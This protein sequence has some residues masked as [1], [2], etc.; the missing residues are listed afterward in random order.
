MA[1]WECEHSADS[2]A[3]P[4]SVWERYSDV[5]MW[6]EW[7][8]GVEES[9]LDGEFEAG[10]KGTLKAP[11]LP[12]SRFE[13]AEVEPERR[14]VSTSRLPGG[15]IRLEH[16][17]EP[18]DAGTR[19]THRATIDGPLSPVWTRVVGR[20]VERDLHASVDRLAEIAVEKEEEARREADEDRRREER[21]AKADERF[22]EEIE[23]TSTGEGD[24]GGASLPGG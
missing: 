23:K 15:T 21:L 5:E 7:S 14:F 12:R 22:K 10:S 8:R 4:P 16:V 18:I 24:G 6:R 17:L 19:I 9:S 20:V 3:P 1:G 2:E 11:Q 13:L